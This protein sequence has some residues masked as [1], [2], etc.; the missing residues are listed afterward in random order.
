MG[1]EKNMRGSLTNVPHCKVTLYV[2]CFVPFHT[3][4]R[5]SN[6]KIILVISSYL[7]EYSKGY[8]EGVVSFKVFYRFG[9][10]V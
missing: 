7:Q 1:S 4:N 2:V 5:L 8:R 10:L 9:V 3:I 6:I